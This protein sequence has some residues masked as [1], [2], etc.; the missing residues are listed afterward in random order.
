MKAYQ[1]DE[2]LELSLGFE[3]NARELYKS[4]SE[5]FIAVPD[6]AAFWSEYASDEDIHAR[7]LEEL[8]ARL[9]PEQL[10]TPIET[11]LVGDTKRLLTYL[12]KEQNI[13]DLEQAFHFANMIETSE[14]NP[15]FEA[16]LSTFEPDEKEITSLRSQLNEHIG[17]LTYQFPKRCARPEPSAR[18]RRSRP[19]VGQFVCIAYR[20]GYDKAL[21]SSL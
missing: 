5:L 20:F 21:L 13:E 7:L 4:W 19:S 2:L 3:Q 9:T 18:R 10:A 1:A 14:I 12:Q 6:V 15:L 8:R 16:I 11:E 17:K